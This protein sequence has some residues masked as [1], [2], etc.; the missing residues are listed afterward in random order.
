MRSEG[1]L[2]GVFGV[3]V[4]NILM[5]LLINYQQFFFKLVSGLKRNMK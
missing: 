2:A 5:A 3:V 4:F 1:G